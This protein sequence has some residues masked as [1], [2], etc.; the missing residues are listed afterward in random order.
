M[1]S[2]LSTSGGIILGRLLMKSTRLVSN[3]KVA[4]FHSEK[5]ST[6]THSLR[7]HFSIQI[8]ISF[9]RLNKSFLKLVLDGCSLNC[10]PF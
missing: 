3:K 2:S 5:L 4:T 10:G 1:F 9:L 8:A 6:G 7:A